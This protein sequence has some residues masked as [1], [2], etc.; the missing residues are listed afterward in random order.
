LSQDGEDFFAPGLNL[1]GGVEFHSGDG[2]LGASLGARLHLAGKP[3]DDA[4]QGAG[5][6]ALMLGVTYR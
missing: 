6:L 5:F 2:P 4:F 3:A 1:G